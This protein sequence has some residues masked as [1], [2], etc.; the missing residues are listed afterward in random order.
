LTG[1]PNPCASRYSDP[2]LRAYPRINKARK[3]RVNVAFVNPNN[4]PPSD[5]G[6]SELE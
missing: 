6:T 4:M 2:M 1:L 3:L 5:N